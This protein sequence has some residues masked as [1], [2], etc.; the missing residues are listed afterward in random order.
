L[1]ETGWRG[2]SPAVRRLIADLESEFDL[3]RLERYMADLQERDERLIREIDAL[4]RARFQAA[5]SSIHE[6]VPPERAPMRRRWWRLVRREGRIVWLKARRGMLE[7]EWRR[8][9]AMA[10]D[11]RFG[12]RLTG[13][14]ST[15]E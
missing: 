6:D 1:H 14:K 10:D 3:L 13:A 5:S 8:C 7:E 11:I 2:E 9:M 4:R 15:R 12:M